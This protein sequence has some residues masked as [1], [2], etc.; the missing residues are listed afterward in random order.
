MVKITLKP[1]PES[2]RPNPPQ[3]P[4]FIFAFEVSAGE[5]FVTVQPLLCTRTF[6]LDEIVCDPTPE[7][8]EILAEILT[9]RGLLKAS[10]NDQIPATVLEQVEAEDIS[11]YIEKQSDDWG[12]ETEDY[13]YE[14]LMDRMQSVTILSCNVVRV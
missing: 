8:S 7:D 14:Q 5:G 6:H 9:E 1:K 4:D 12:D 3:Y 2:V 11:K 13:L 10:H